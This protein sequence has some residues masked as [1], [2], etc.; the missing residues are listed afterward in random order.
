MQKVSE[1]LGHPLNDYLLYDKS[2]MLE[3][4]LTLNSQAV[5]DKTELQLIRRKDLEQRT[6]CASC[7]YKINIEIQASLPI[8]LEVYNDEKIG[9]II[10]RVN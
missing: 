7:R 8:W 6:Y 3:N 4:S 10:E 2:R 1:R 5:H 9:D